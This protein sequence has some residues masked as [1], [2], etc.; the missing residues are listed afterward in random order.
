M[1][2]KLK[3]IKILGGK[4]IDL[5]YTINENGYVIGTKG[6]IELVL[7]MSKIDKVFTE[8]VSGDAPNRYIVSADLINSK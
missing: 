8:S 2:D 5:T 6:D 4:G 7:D 1:M 3:D